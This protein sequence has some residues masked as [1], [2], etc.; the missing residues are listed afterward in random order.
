MKTYR[1]LLIYT[2]RETKEKIRSELKEFPSY[3]ISFISY[4]NP[5]LQWCWANT[6]E[7]D[8]IIL[9]FSQTNNF[10]M[11]FVLSLVHHKT[12][13]PI[14]PII[15]FAQGELIN[16]L[17][18]LEIYDFI[19]KDESKSYL[20]YI[21]LYFDHILEK[22]K[23]YIKKEYYKQISIIQGELTEALN[24][25]GNIQDIYIIILS[26]LMKLKN[27]EC[28]VIYSVTPLNGDY[29][30]EVACNLPL[31]LE[32]S[33][34]K[35]SQDDSIAKILSRT[36]PVYT[37]MSQIYQLLPG[38]EGYESLRATAFIPIIFQGKQLA[39]VCLSSF[40][41]DE[42][43]D[44]TQ[45][46]IEAFTNQIGGY[47]ERIRM[48]E[49]AARRENILKAVTYGAE[50][51]LRHYQTDKALESLRYFLKLL[52]EASNVSRIYLFKNYY[53]EQGELFMCHT[54]EWAKDG[55]DPQIDQKILQALAYADFPSLKEKL[56][57]GEIYGG[58]VKEMPEYD[59]SILE[60]QNVL[61]L[62][63]VPIF[64]CNSWWGYIGFDD[65]EVE[66]DWTESELSTLRI[67]GGIIGIAMCGKDILDTQ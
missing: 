23:D 48:E 28:G 20:S 62:A 2:Y 57:T 63:L 60:P 15:D 4:D 1:L 24:N 36:T 34:H 6:E 13:I 22:H 12:E 18:H 64:C 61:S 38:I 41:S 5:E 49:L 21:A 19:P 17:M 51:F 37:H 65:C 52:G 33:I 56:E 44:R 46:V 31:Q 16:Q 42:I 39:V 7:Y 50:E 53:D 14:I 47:I 43:S 54:A 40:S 26:S 25:G 58:L 66:R 32:K 29:T 10:G 8:A 3:H 55:I 59:R 9:E 30:Q 35:Y 11:D 45:R 27:I 67:A